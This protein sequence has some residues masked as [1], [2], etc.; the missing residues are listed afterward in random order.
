VEHLKLLKK[1]S[2]LPQI[3]V[4]L[5]GFLAA[6]VLTG[7]N[8]PNSTPE[9]L[10]PIY[11]DLV[12]ELGKTQN[13]IKTE[14]EELKAAKAKVDKLQPRDIMKA[15]YTREYQARVKRMKGLEER[16]MYFETRAKQRK[17]FARREY[18]DAFQKGETWPKPEEMSSYLAAKKLQGASRSWDDR[19]PKMTR[20]LRAQPDAMPPADGEKKDNTTE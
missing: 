18:L 3:R 10:D 15:T 2:C 13:L 16:L 6:L 8:R 19:V 12:N 5:V 7:C 17:Q 4:L 9:E 1:W 11:K 20:H 14:E